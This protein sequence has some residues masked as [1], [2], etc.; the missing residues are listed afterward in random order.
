MRSLLLLIL[1]AA[2]L[3]ITEVC[4]LLSLSSYCI[5]IR[6]HSQN[7]PRGTRIYLQPC[8]LKRC[9]L[10]TFVSVCSN[11]LKRTLSAVLSVC[12]YRNDFSMMI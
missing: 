2:V 5:G 6:G 12:K 7:R 4:Y 11:L 1:M 10:S 3:S 9:L 8:T